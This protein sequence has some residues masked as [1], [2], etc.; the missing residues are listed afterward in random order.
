MTDEQEIR[1]GKK[2]TREK[3]KQASTT[4]SIKWFYGVF[5]GITTALDF[6]A[7]RKSCVPLFMPLIGQS[8][9]EFLD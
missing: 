6:I 4:E 7:T 8:R 5:I 3:V 9:R 2:I 1:A